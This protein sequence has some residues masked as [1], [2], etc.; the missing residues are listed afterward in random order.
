MHTS[1]MGQL[2]VVLVI[3]Y[4]VSHYA[5]ILFDCRATSSFVSLDFVKRSKLTGRLVLEF[6]KG[7]SPGGLISILVV[8]LGCLITIGEDDFMANLMVIP[9]PTFDVILSM[10]WLHRHRDRVV[11]SCF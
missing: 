2:D 5:I 3:L 10:D 8:C 7:S 9:L 1:S 4:D 11:I 6:V